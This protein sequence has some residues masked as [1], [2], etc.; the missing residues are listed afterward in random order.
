MPHTDFSLLDPSTWLPS[1]VAGGFGVY[2]LVRLLRRDQRQDQKDQQVDAATMQ[3]ITALREEVSRVT[4]R[5]G[6]M[7]QEIVRLH[8]ERKQLFEELARIRVRLAEYEGVP[9]TPPLF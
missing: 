5:M 8:A 1:L 4:T 3:V 7:E 6:D 9:V 2:Y